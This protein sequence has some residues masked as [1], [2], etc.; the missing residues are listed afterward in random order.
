MNATNKVCIVFLIICGFIACG[1][2]GAA[3]GSRV[4]DARIIGLERERDDLAGRLAAIDAD[5]GLARQSL[6]SVRERA[7]SIG[8]GLEKSIVT[9]GTIKDRNERI[10]ILVGSIRTCINELRDVVLW[11]ESGNHHD[12]E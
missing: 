3:I 2:L 1:F 6:G 10:A 9:A 8:S 11:L 12:K 7:V 5:L 4:A